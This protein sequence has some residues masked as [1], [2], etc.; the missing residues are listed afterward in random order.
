MAEA[1]KNRY[2]CESLRKLALDI[3]SVY[4]GVQADEF[5]QATIDETWE[6]REF[7]RTFI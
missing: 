4:N 1:I 3:K 7:I 5:L 2:N 6:E